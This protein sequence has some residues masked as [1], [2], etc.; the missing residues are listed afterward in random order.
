VKQFE[1]GILGVTETTT[2]RI[3]CAL[4]LL[5]ATACRQLGLKQ[6]SER[7]RYAHALEQSGISRTALGAEWERAGSEAIQEPVRITT[8]YKESG[9]FPGDPAEAVGLRVRVVQGQRLM[10]QVE[11]DVRESTLLFLDLFSRDSAGQA[12][13]LVSADSG[14]RGLDVEI[15]RS[16]EFVIRL[17]PELLR[18]ARYTLTIRTAPVL[19]MPVQ[20]AGNSAIKSGFGVDRDAGKRRH[21]GIDIFAPKGTP[22]LAATR[23]RITNVG[24]NGLGGRVVWEWDDE[25]NQSLYYAHLDV[26]LAREGMMVERGDTIGL[27]G[28]TGNAR[29]TPSHLHFGIYRRGEGA[30]DPYGFVHQPPSKTLLLSADTGQLGKLA[31]I[32]NP[33]AR[34]KTSFDARAPGSPL[35]RETIVRIEAGSADQFRVE[36]PDGLTGFVS[37][38]AVESVEHPTGS[39][40]TPVAMALLEEPT[41]AAL[42][43]DSLAAGTTIQIMGRFGNYV[44]A[45]RAS[46]ETGWVHWKGR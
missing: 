2:K 8:P 7:E 31:R 4:I 27:V 25:R 3:F 15:E 30:I 10:I 46:G 9:Y 22:V 44:M 14:L 12:T 42:I 39:R 32:T 19:G 33:T 45:R 23:G 24:E 6:T 34:L 41:V 35:E 18:S 29:T 17:Q 38:T 13:P 40:K 36:L 20:G 37:S 28:N 26:Q 21:E 43:V 5:T 16:G 11:K 1:P